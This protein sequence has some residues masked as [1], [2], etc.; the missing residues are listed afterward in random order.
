MLCDGDTNHHP[1][2]TER[3]VDSNISPQPEGFPKTPATLTLWSHLRWP[4]WRAPAV[5]AVVRGMIMPGIH[6][7]V[8]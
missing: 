5:K 3:I 7:T 6:P 4:L 2:E 1:A 8:A